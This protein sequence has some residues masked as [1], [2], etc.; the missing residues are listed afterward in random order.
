MTLC[1]D[2]GHLRTSDHPAVKRVNELENQG[3]RVLKQALA[4]LF[5]GETPPVE[6]IKWKEIYDYLEEAIDHCEDTVTVVE[7]ALVKNS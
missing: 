4:D 7:A 2:L 6:V 3:D 1:A 5:C